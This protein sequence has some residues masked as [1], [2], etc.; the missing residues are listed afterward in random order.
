MRM[1]HIS[2]K[3]NAKDNKKTKQKK[4]THT[5]KKKKNLW[6]LQDCIPTYSKLSKESLWQLSS[7]RNLY[8]CVCSVPSHV[9][10]KVKQW[11]ARQQWNG[12]HTWS[13]PLG[14]QYS[15]TCQPIQFTSIKYSFFSLI[16]LGGY[17]HTGK[18]IQENIIFMRFCCCFKLSK[19]IEKLSNEQPMNAIIKFTLAVLSAIGE[20]ISSEVRI[21]IWSCA[22]IFSTTLLLPFTATRTDWNSKCL[23]YQRKKKK[24]P[25]PA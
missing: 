7:R 3:Q 12:V 2:E 22:C 15:H 19:K 11:W 21:V 13:S 24:R 1:G 5:Q 6:M 23:W 20:E 4:H 16:I 25:R 8:F 14:M 9:C 17:D 18:W 10:K